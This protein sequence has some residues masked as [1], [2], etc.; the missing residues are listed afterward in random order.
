MENVKALILYKNNIQPEPRT[1][2]RIPL[3]RLA[4]ILYKNNIQP[5]SYPGHM[6]R[7]PTR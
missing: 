7:L 1:V 4:L 6:G 2:G 3:Q 5:R